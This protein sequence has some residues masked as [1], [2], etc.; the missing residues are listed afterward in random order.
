MKFKTWFLLTAL[1]L[2][3]AASAPGA[4]AQIT[5][6]A[7]C[8]YDAARP[9]VKDYAALVSPKD[10]MR[11]NPKARV[12][13]IEIFEPNC[14]H[15]ASLY[16]VMELVARQHKD[17]ARFYYKPVMFWKEPSQV[18]V[19]ALYAA[20]EAGKYFPMLEHQFLMQRQG[21]LQTAEVRQIAEKIGMNA[22]ALEASIKAGKYV[23]EINRERARLI[24]TY[25]VNSVPM[26][27]INGRVV[28]SAGR[29]PECLGRLI[30]EAA[31]AK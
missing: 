19:Q 26:V 13:V 2:C 7:E 20:A 29:T 12:T 28:A 16:P 6:T 9:V 30:R 21:G 14:P 23:D 27:L 17:A 1:A 31:A 11:G 4:H 15:C 5:A 8:A 10:P 22:A 3:A 24:D 25:K 18:Q